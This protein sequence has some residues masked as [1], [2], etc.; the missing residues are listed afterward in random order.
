MSF[1]LTK[2]QLEQIKDYLLL[3]YGKKDTQLTRANLPLSGQELLAIVQNGQNKVIDIN[4]ILGTGCSLVPDEEDLTSVRRS[5]ISLLKFKDKA[6]TPST[7]SGMGRKI[8]RKNLVNGVNRLV[9]SMM[10]VA[11][12]EGAT[13]PGRNT[14]YIIQYDYDF[15]GDRKETLSF[16]NATTVVTDEYTTALAKYN[17]AYA[18]YVE[19]QEDLTD[20]QEALG[21]A[22]DYLAEL[23]DSG[24]ATEEEIDAAEKAVY[25]AKINMEEAGDE[26]SKANA[27]QTELYAVLE[28]T[29]HYY[30]YNTVNLLAGECLYLKG[31]SVGLDQNRTEITY[32]K[33]SIIYAEENMT[34][35]IG[36][37]DGTFE[38]KI[39]HYVKAPSNSILMFCGGSLKNGRIEGNN[40]KIIAAK[41][42]IFDNITIGGTWNVPEITS[43]WFADA[44]SNNK[45]KEVFALQDDNV[46]N[47]IVVEEGNYTLSA[48]YSG[49]SI[50]PLKSNLNLIINGN[51]NLQT[52][53]YDSYFIL[54]II[55]KDH[56]NISGSGSIVGDKSTHIGTTGQWG[57][58]I[59]VQGNFVNIEGL[60]IK[61]CWGDAICVG[62][63]S[64][65]TFTINKV[66]IENCFLDD[67]RRQGISVTHAENVVIRNCHITRIGIGEKGHNPKAAI[68]IEPNK[69]NHAYN[70]L[71]ENCRIE[72]CELGVVIYGRK[73]YTKSNISIDNCYIQC[74]RRGIA[75]NGTSGT[76]KVTNCKIH[77]RFHVVD[78]NNIS[79]AQDN[80]ILFEN[81][82][83]VQQPEE[84][85]DMSTD[86]R[87]CAIFAVKGDFCFRHNAITCTLPVFRLGNGNKFIEDNDITCGDLFFPRQYESVRIIGNR[88]NGNVTIPGPRTIFENNTV[89]GLLKSTAQYT[90]IDDQQQTVTVKIN[91]K[92]SVVRGNY[93]TNVV[94]G[95]AIA[96]FRN[97]ILFDGNRFTNV[98]IKLPNKG[99][100]SNNM[101]NFN[102]K[103]TLTGILLDLGFCDFVNNV[104]SYNGTNAQ[105]SNIYLVRCGKT[106]IGNSFTST[107]RIKYVIYHGGTGSCFVSG[108]RI[109]LPVGHEA[110]H[111]IDSYDS[112]VIP[113]E[114]TSGS[115]SE[116]PVLPQGD[117]YYIGLRYY[118][119]TINLPIFW[120]RYK[121]MDAAGNA[122]TWPIAYKLTNITT[123]NTDQPDAGESYS[124]VLSAARGYALPST[125][126]V[127]I[128]TTTLDSSTDYTYNI[129]TGA[130][131]ILGI[132]GT[133]GVTDEL[134][135]D[136]AAA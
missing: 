66:V 65:Q 17:K 92:Y 101:F 40:T 67:C 56:I 121:W 21:E 78:A 61:E 93:I 131:E 19:A 104:V 31:T 116:R 71:V 75:I 118:D 105:D 95:N 6:Y 111:I 86:V 115:K 97:R 4:N 1:V 70:I 49:D 9:Q 20:A 77:T 91:D 76:V 85:D 42:A 68:D 80:V 25:D 24:T 94:E 59:Y 41:T 33:G 7:Y 8:L 34:V 99:V 15:G 38:F 35:T 44:T 100:L 81:N 107:S 10:P 50:L 113:N 53:N 39:E 55:G 109:T 64:S 57:H 18:E 90:T 87:G 48:T 123:S 73:Y 114:R 51:L 127:K 135:I 2:G 32:E 63:S 128:G 30:S 130:V 58:G 102:S 106:V 72:D 120:D 43:A 136:A 88:I 69:N 27:K 133:G 46:L 13:D 83:I 74:V 103:F 124:T 28:N 60:T 79:A 108:N 89:T 126:T 62:K 23:I 84:G 29:Q 110:D 11:T 96:V 47:T 16:S 82:M 22:E 26:V 12:E 3:Y 117:R 129:I 45:L 125:I 52:N 5:G 112:T 119:T 36:N 37:H 98:A 54:H 14:I 132:G 122:I 134:T